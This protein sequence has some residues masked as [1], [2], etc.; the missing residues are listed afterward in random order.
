MD[1]VREQGTAEA[2]E[3]FLDVFRRSRLGVIAHGLPVN[4][5]G[6]IRGGPGVTV[7]SG[8]H[9]RDGRSMVLA[10]ADLATFRARFHRRFN[11]ELDAASLMNI[12]LANRDAQVILIN[13]AISEHSIIIDRSTVERLVAVRKPW[14]R[15]W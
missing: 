2:Y 1:L 3:R 12:V 6:L 4:A 9:P 15:F 13:S 11:A 10:C 5:S 8:E 14:W 7:S